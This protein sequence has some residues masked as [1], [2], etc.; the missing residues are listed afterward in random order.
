ME[1]GNYADITIIKKEKNIFKSDKTFTK[2]DFSPFDGL[3]VECKI[4]TVIIDG[5]VILENG[6]FK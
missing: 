5:E 1:K 2:A 6:E 3:R 4:D